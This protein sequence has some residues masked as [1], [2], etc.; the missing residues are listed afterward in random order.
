MPFVYLKATELRPTGKTIS[1]AE[2]PEFGN[3]NNYNKKKQTWH[4]VRA[5]LALD[6]PLNQTKQN[7][8]EGRQTKHGAPTLTLAY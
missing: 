1:W 4:Q 6:F 5:Q 2:P 8:S 7:E 3:R